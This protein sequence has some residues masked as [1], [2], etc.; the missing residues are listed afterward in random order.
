MKNILMISW[1]MGRYDWSVKICDILLKLT[2]FRHAASALHSFL[3]LGLSSS[4]SGSSF[5][6]FVCYHC[7]NDT[8]D[9]CYSRAFSFS[10]VIIGLIS[11]RFSFIAG[12]CC[13]R[14]I[15]FSFTSLLCYNKVAK[16]RTIIATMTLISSTSWPLSFP[17]DSGICLPSPSP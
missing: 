13:L 5:R 4:F 3:S 8:L 16:V 11:G 17:T 14:S 9:G 7:G 15:C 6:F 2:Y 1:L 10:F 12:S